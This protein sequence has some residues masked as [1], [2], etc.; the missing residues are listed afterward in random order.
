MRPIALLALLAALAAAGPARAE[1]DDAARQARC[2]I[3]AMPCSAIARSRMAPA[4]SWLEAPARALDAALVP[5]TIDSRGAGQG[6]DGLS[7]DRREPVA[8]GRDL[9]FRPGPPIPMSCA[10]GSGSTPIP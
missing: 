10:R 7:G 6:Q 3:C 9:S 4:P 1:E 5:I 2:R 8:A